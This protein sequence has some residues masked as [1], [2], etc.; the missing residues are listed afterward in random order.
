[1]R[2]AEIYA[3]PLIRV[4]GVIGGVASVVDG[5]ALGVKAWDARQNGD[6]S[7][8]VLY[9]LSSGATIISGAL[10]IFAGFAGDFALF[11]PIGICI[12]LA[13]LGAVLATMAADEVRSPLEVWLSD[14]CFGLKR[15]EHEKHWDANSLD[16]LQAAMKAY[17]TIAS[18]VSAQI[19]RERM[20]EVMLNSAGTGLV[21]VQVKLPGCSKLGSDWLIELTAK[22]SGGSQLLA[23]SVSSGKV[24]NVKTAAKQSFDINPMGMGSATLSADL[25][26]KESWET[27]GLLLQGEF[28]F[29]SMKFSD[30]E[31]KVT[32]WPDKLKPEVNLQLI[33]ST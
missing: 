25:V 21:A 1:M 6:F 3:H 16:D 9:A 33:T 15:A 5:I 28:A 11:G 17:Y 26:M 30:V 19:R 27:S 4:A 32:Y 12:G 2:G 22:G 24:T 20:A 14:T 10:G 29:N 23:Q 8:E 13:I 7:A 31:L 18:G